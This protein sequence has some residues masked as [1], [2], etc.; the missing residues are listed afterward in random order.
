LLSH[1]GSLRRLR[2][3]SIEEL[4]RTAGVSESL[5]TTIHDVLGAVSA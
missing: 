3:A 2:E 1:F 5:A 4:R